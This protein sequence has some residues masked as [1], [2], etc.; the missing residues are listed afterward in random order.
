MDERLKEVHQTD[1]TESRVNEEFVDW[2]KTKGVSWLLIV[3]LALCAYLI[4]VRWK[5]RK[6]THFNNAWA[7]YL[8]SE[9]SQLPSSFEDVAEEYGDVGAIPAL[10]RIRAAERLLRS[11]QTDRP[12]GVDA[13]AT[14]T[15][16]TDERQQ[17]LDRADRLYARVIEDDDGSLGMM[18]LVVNAINGRAALAE[19]R[20]DLDEAARLYEQAAIVAEGSY[21][22]LAAQARARAA[23]SAE[24]TET[25]VFSSGATGATRLPATAGRPA[26]VEPA[27]RDLLLGDDAG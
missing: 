17:Y 23:T 14:A 10:A 16:T 15:L 24:Q 18:L 27:L 7:A 22:G 19:S 5:E 21:P 13:A 6:A 3:L 12:L 20:G 26:F 11:I 8:E 4:V 1:L 9:Q 25:V 2:L